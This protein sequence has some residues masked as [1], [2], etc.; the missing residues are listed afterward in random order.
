MTQFVTCA[1]ADKRLPHLQLCRE[2]G[3]RHGA[4][5]R[6]VAG[7]LPARFPDHR[8]SPPPPEVGLHRSQHS[9]QGKLGCIFLLA[10]CGASVSLRAARSPKQGRGDVCG[11][12][13]QSI[14]TICGC[15][16]AAYASTS[17]QSFLPGTYAQLHVRNLKSVR[18]LMPLSSKMLAAAHA[19]REMHSQ[20]PQHG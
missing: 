11:A 14:R 12:R 4:E 16:T 13:H 2:L 19:C 1:C 5:V 6:W 7:A 8:G 17:L 10:A 18:A 20:E 9:Q 3:R 15:W